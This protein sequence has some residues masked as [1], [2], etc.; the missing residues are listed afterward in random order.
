MATAPSPNQSLPLNPSPTQNETAPDAQPDTGNVQATS[1]LDTLKGPAPSLEAYANF[2]SSSPPTLLRS[3]R[4]HAGKQ[5][6][7][8]SCSKLKEILQQALG[9][10]ASIPVPP[11]TI[12]SGLREIH[13]QCRKRKQDV[14]EGKPIPP[15]DLIDLTNEPD[16][17]NDMEKFPQGSSASKTSSKRRRM[18]DNKLSE[19]QNISISLPTKPS[20]PSPPL[21]ERNLHDHGAAKDVVQSP[22][23]HASP[24]TTQDTVGVTPDPAGL[25]PSPSLTLT[26]PE[27]TSTPLSLISANHGADTATSIPS[28]TEPKIPINPASTSSTLPNVN[29]SSISQPGSNSTGPVGVTNHPEGLAPPPPPI[30]ILKPASSADPNADPAATSDPNTTPSIPPPPASIPSLILSDSVRAEV[31]S[32][33]A[34]FQ[35]NLNRQKFKQAHLAVHAFIDCRAKSMHKR[36]PPPELPQFAL[37]QSEASHTAWLK[38]IQKY[39]D[40]ILLPSHD[41]PWYSPRLI[42][43]SN[44]KSAD[45]AALKTQGH[46]E[47]PLALLLLEIQKPSKFILSRWSNCIASSIQLTA[48][49]HTVKPSSLSDLNHDNL[50]SH[51]RILEYLNG[52]KTSSASAFNSEDGKFR[53]DMTLKPL[54]QLHDL[55]INIFITYSIIRGSVVADVEPDATSAESQAL[56]VQKKELDKHRSRHNYTPL[57]CLYLVAGVRGLILAPNNRQFASGALAL[58]FLSAVEHIFN[59]NI[60]RHEGLEPVWKRLGAYI[61]NLFIEAFLTPNCLF[62]FCQPQIIP[63]AQA[64]TSDF[65]ACVQNQFP[66][67][68][69]KLPRA[70]TAK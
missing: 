44:L 63:L 46:V 60:P 24:P 47:Y 29:P 30:I 19:E 8:T 62:N 36:T 54:Y 3:E 2:N 41:E 56:V 65:L 45:P 4:R 55:I 37:V 67:R 22:I 26:G 52:C 53:N 50:D 27:V 57:I 18:E 28:S 14:S 21:G 40:T 48:Q 61:D 32:I 70:V 49:E 64:I 33:L 59:K 20:D 1:A 31:H 25:A 5:E 43:M 12:I 23:K 7:V 68:N 10:S 16:E 69:F 17:E 39:L 11:A 9:L 6:Y 34:S 13:E 38:D 35:G 15:E 58:G 42:D 51:L 66:A